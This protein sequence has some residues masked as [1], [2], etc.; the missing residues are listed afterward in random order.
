MKE[1]WKDIVD[2]EGFYQVSN[3]GRV[4]SLARIKLRSNGNP[5][6]FK[7]RILRPGLSNGYLSVSLRG[8]N[9]EKKTHLVHRLVAVHFIENADNLPEVNHIGKDEDGNITK[10]DNRAVSLEWV[11]VREN[12]IHGW[13]NKQFK[14]SKYPGVSFVVKNG[15]WAASIR[16]N[17]KSKSLGHFLSETKAAE[18]YQRELEK[19]C[20]KNRYAKCHR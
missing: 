6:S 19:N 1:V 11:S 8:Y 7:E 10:L 2:Y 14:S 4:K 18:A 12:S 5:Q 20:I 16:I 17:G 9:G 13:L 3:L 15:K